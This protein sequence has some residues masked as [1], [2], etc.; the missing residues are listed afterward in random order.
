MGCKLVLRQVQKQV[1]VISKT[2]CVSYLD[3]RADPHRAPFQSQAAY[4]YR[5]SRHDARRRK[6]FFSLSHS[7]VKVRTSSQQAC[8]S[9]SAVIYMF[10]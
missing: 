6:F 5:G 9:A 3:G 10:Q 8:L 2:V 4:G 1:V 7:E